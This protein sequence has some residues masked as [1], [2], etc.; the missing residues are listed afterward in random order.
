MLDANVADTA[1]ELA[2]ARAGSDWTCTRCGGDNR[3]GVRIC[4]G[5]GAA[6]EV[7]A[8]QALTRAA[9]SQR[10]TPED[11]PPRPGSSRLWGIAVLGGIGLFGFG[12]VGRDIYV[13]EWED[14]VAGT[15]SA[16]RWTHTVEVQIFQPV[17]SGGWRAGLVVSA[18][19]MPVD[20]T[21][22]D[23]GV[24]NIR[25]C[26][27]RH[28]HDE[29]YECGT[30]RV[31]E[32]RS[33]EVSDGETCHEVCNTTSNGNGSFT[34]TCDDVC[35]PGWRTEYYEEC[36]DATKYC[37]RPI[38]AEWC[39]FDTYQ[40]ATSDTLVLNGENPEIDVLPWPTAGATGLERLRHT[41]AY[42]ISYA[43][44]FEEEARD[45]TMGVLDEETLLSWRVG[46]PVT[47]VVNYDG[48]VKDVKRAPR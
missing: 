1:E 12:L 42:N 36:H 25:D 39:T 16:T 44:T 13:M 3:A 23:P 43:Y 6:F 11:V 40:W 15:V 47:L 29:S 35:S 26:G 41:G 2:I 24:A 20:G 19:V 4:E 22:E 8:V 7:A 31:C 27:M 17:V 32:Q 46:E 30:E 33:R 10:P 38:E 45:Y 28:H 37:S 18:P 34:E 21:G 14:E 5:C 9:P 48:G